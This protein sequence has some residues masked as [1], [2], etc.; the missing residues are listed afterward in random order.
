[1][2][3]REKKKC[4]QELE[5]RNI[6]KKNGCHNV[7][8][9]NYIRRVANEVYLSNRKL[10]HLLHSLP[11][12]KENEAWIE[13]YRIINKY[14]TDNNMK[15]TKDIIDIEISNRFPGKKDQLEKEPTDNYS[16]LI[17]KKNSDNS[18]PKINSTFESSSA[19]DDELANILIPES[20]EGIEE[21]NMTNP[22][23]F[24]FKI[25]KQSESASDDLLSS[26]S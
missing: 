5:I 20:S 16:E 21:N 6:L 8:R 4:L 7:M 2:S 26:D 24:I 12:W 18:T 25:K 1:M 13:S 22:Y 10:F 19:P 15:M 17:R 11:E 9:A 23:V 14:L 3:F